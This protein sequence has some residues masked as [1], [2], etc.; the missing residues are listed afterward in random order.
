MRK[1]FHLMGGTIRVLD[2]SSVPDQF[3]PDL[4]GDPSAGQGRIES[5][6][7][8]MEAAQ[9]SRAPSLAAATLA[10]RQEHLPSPSAI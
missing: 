9:R 2:V 7:Q 3:A 6:P 1:H 8:R 5:V 10:D 4:L